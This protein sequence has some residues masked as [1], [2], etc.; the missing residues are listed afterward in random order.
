MKLFKKKIKLLYFE[1]LAS[2]PGGLHEA[3]GCLAVQRELKLQ[4]Q[5]SL[6]L[7]TQLCPLQA[8]WEPQILI[9]HGPA[10]ELGPRWLLFI[11]QSS[12]PLGRSDLPGTSLHRDTYIIAEPKT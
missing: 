8:L 11:T 4:E 2:V 9:S 5:G 10:G 12:E 6:G 7:E 1:M 3:S